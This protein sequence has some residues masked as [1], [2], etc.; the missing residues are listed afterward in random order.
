MQCEEKV[1]KL[2]AWIGHD[3]EF[4]GHDIRHDYLSEN[5]GRDG[6][7]YLW[8]YDGTTNAIIDADGN[9]C[10]DSDRINELFC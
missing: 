5:T 10:E 9:I 7:D 3:T 4:V 1:D 6:K 2:Y 8:H